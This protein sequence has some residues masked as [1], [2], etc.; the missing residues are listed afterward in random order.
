MV[1]GVED[2][3]KNWNCKA[4]GGDDLPVVGVTK[5]I[6]DGVVDVGEC[7]IDE[8]RVLFGL[9]GCVSARKINIIFL[10]KMKN[11]LR[12]DNFFTIDTGLAILDIDIV[13]KSGFGC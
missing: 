10:I 7:L 12:S 1:V 6:D 5:R 9:S 4:V 11:H 2:L 8:P 13:G 3:S